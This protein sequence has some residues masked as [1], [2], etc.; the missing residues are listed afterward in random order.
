ML[1]KYKKQD[2][3]AL[4]ELINK[5]VNEG[6]LTMEQ[7]DGLIERMENMEKRNRRFK[8][9]GIVT[10]SLSLLL[11]IGMGL[12][13]RGGLGGSIST[14]FFTINDQNVIQRAGSGEHA[15]PIRLDIFDREGKKRFSMGIDLEG[16]PRLKFFDK[17]Q[18]ILT[19][20]NAKHDGQ[21]VIKLLDR[22]G[23][24][25]ISEKSQPVLREQEHKNE[26]AKSNY[27]EATRTDEPQD[28]RKTSEADYGG[29]PDKKK[30]SIYLAAPKGKA[31]H[32]PYC[33]WVKNIPLD[34]LLKFSSIEDA[35]KAGY[36]SC[37]L[38]RPNG[39]N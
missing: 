6:S 35:T 36:R 10:L 13:I 14:N 25:S 30:P 34:N 28:G 2:L 17:D 19:E 5:N 32:Y 7:H 12:L 39:K 38:C 8:I 3:E 9:I 18:Q 16:E 21:I 22:G 37:R 1:G 20:F 33:P 27:P 31:Y 29:I 23:K 24:K 15:S 4:T 26:T 11:W